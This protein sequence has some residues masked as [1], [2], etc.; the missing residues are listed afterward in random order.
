MTILSLLLVA[1]CVNINNILSKKFDD[2]SVFWLWNVRSM[3]ID[4]ELSG[5]F[6]VVWLW[7]N[8]SVLS[9]S[10]I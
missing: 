5:Y 7:V 9:L 4:D 3:V 8:P 10:I 2:G 6:V 1:G